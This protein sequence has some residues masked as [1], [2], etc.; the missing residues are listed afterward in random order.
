M[1]SKI[2]AVAV[3]LLASRAEAGGWS[4]QIRGEFIGG[5]VRA[6]PGQNITEASASVYCNCVGDLLEAKYSEQQ[7]MKESTARSETFNA[8]IQSTT[9]QCA[10]H[11]AFAT[12]PGQ[13]GWSST[14]RSAF[15]GSCVGGAT[16]KGADEKKA[17]K[18]CKCMGHALERNY[19]ENAFA[20]ASFKPSDKYNSDLQDA[21]KVCVKE[22]RK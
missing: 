15:V 5:C 10:K 22:F 8:A 13:K 1:A 11:I 7:F 18:Y 20:Q 16:E 6:A 14:F 9:A 19:D 21:A 2:F 12:R 4:K 17:E 3:V